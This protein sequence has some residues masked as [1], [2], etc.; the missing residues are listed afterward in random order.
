MRETQP[1][2]QLPNSGPCIIVDDLTVYIISGKSGN[3]NFI[4][5][6]WIGTYEKIKRYDKL[7][8]DEEARVKKW[9]FVEGFPEYGREHSTC[10]ID[11]SDN[12]SDIVVVGGNM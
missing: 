10:Y 8:K 11:K 1:Q 5:G 7:P 4:K 12:R 3:N 9:T 6:T 2:A